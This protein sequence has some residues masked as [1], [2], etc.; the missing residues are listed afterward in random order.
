MISVHLLDN[1]ENLFPRDLVSPGPGS[2][3]FRTREWLETLRSGLS[4]FKLGV[5][6]V[7]EPAGG[8]NRVKAVMPFFLE[9]RAGW[10]CVHSLPFS[11]YG[12]LMVLRGR[13]LP[14]RSDIAR[15]VGKFHRLTSRPLLLIQI[16]DYS[17][18]L[19]GNL[20]PAF[21]TRPVFAH[22][23]DLSGG[24]GKVW[25]SRFS[26]RVRKFVRQAERSGV[27]IVKVETEVDLEK[28]VKVAGDTRLRHGVK[29]YPDGFFR[30]AVLGPGA[31]RVSV[32]LAVRSGKVLA[33]SMHLYGRETVFNWFTASYPEGWSYRPVQALVSRVVR[34]ACRD[35]FRWYN[36]GASPPGARG[37]VYFKEGF[38]A[39]RYD[40]LIHEYRSP[41][42][43]F[44]GALKTP[45]RIAAEVRRL[46]S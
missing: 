46:R 18:N 36:L 20:P 4:G 34:D 8:K 1:L 26:H 3:P 33:G 21:S 31:G 24:F 5:A 37:L 19:A 14:S 41:V 25:R 43:K 32:H 9:V 38:G 15:L 29:P 22:I 45:A 35:G 7:S 27:E 2:D 11:S 10:A 30:A 28:Y 44:I 40:Y 42:L 6:T 17:G 23:L 12:G 39:F 16:T 13:G